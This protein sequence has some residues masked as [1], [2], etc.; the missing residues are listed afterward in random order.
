MTELSYKLKDGIYS[1]YDGESLIKVI[2][3]E[4]GISYVFWEDDT[5]VRGFI[6][7][8]GDLDLT[9]NYHEQMIECYKG[10]IE[11]ENS[12]SM[13]AEDSLREMYY[14]SGKFDLEE[15]NKFLSISD[16]IARWH[17]KNIQ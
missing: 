16:Y 5:G 11:K 2:G 1:L 10:V 7:K 14:I 13:V 12:L 6:N 4:I 3:E 15:L 17:K 8:H 9:K